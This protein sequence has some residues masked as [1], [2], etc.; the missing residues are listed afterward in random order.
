MINM[1]YILRTTINTLRVYL[2]KFNKAII[3]QRRY[4]IYK[5]ESLKT[6]FFK[7][8]VILQRLKSYYFSN[9]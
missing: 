1:M 3:T 7:A 2:K 6:F 4:F 5:T 9:I 8:I